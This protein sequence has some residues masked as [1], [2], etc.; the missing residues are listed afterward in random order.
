MFRAH[1]MIARATIEDGILASAA[2]ACGRAPRS[3]AG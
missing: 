3:R 2:R 1:G